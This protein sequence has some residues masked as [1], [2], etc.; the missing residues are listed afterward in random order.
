MWSFCKRRLQLHFFFQQNQSWWVFYFPVI[1]QHNLHWVRWAEH[2]LCHKESVFPLHPLRR[3][4]I[5]TNIFLIKT[6]FS[7]HIAQLFCK[8]QMV[9]LFSVT[10]YFMTDYCSSLENMVWFPA[11]LKKIQ[12]KYLCKIKIIFR[13]KPIQNNAELTSQGKNLKEKKCMCKVWYFFF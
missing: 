12:K 7:V 4:R 6:W 3:L 13:Y 11:I 5:F 1:C 8:F 9:C 10:K 2:F